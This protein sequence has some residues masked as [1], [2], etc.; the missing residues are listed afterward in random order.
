MILRKVKKSKTKVK[1]KKSCGRKPNNNNEAS[2]LCLPSTKSAN[3]EILIL[4]L[5]RKWK[6]NKTRKDTLLLVPSGA[7]VAMMDATQGNSCYKQ[8]NA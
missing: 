2:P 8:T 1:I 4:S 3:I 5:R 6:R 7:L